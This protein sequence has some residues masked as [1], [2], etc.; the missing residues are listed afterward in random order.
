MRLFARTSL[1]C[2]L[3]GLFSLPAQ[4]ADMTIKVT[5]P[6]LDTAEY[7]RPYVAIWLQSPDRKTVRDIAVWY[8]TES[9]GE[10]GSQWLKD[11]RQWWRVSGRN[12]GEPADG[13]SGATKAV[14]VHTV[15]VPADHQAL[16]ALPAGDYELLV[17]AAREKGGREL[18][19]LPLAWPPTAEKTLTEKGEAEL[20]DI[21][22]TVRP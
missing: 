20:G 13:V 15:D 18:V 16:A 7:H 22:A 8:Q 6:K 12:Q 19:R 11:L 21:Q 14:G 17:E 3:A 4:A 10:E 2:A 1:I 5:V 9:K